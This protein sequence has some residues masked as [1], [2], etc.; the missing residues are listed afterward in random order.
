ML[1]ISWLTEQMLT[2]QE[3]L[4]FMESFLSLCLS[5]SC[6]SYSEHRASVKRYVSLQFLNPESVGRILWTGDQPV[7]R[8][9]GVNFFLP[10]C[11]RFWRIGLSFLSFLIRDSRQDSL[12]GWSARRKDSTCTQT[13]KNAHTYTNTNIHA[14]SGIRTH[15]P[16]F[17]ASEDSA[18]PR[19]L[20]YRDRL[21]DITSR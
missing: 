3:G 6:C 19:P 7:A 15:S 9:H 4:S 1:E 21:S 2:S 17:R 13:Q 10:R 18:R 16:G 12:D 8:P 11:S 5:V 14:L 20:G